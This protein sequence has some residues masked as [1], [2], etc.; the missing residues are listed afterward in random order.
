MSDIKRYGA[1]GGV[2]QGKQHMPFSR[3]VEAD[4]W[5]FMAVLKHARSRSGKKATLDTFVDCAAY[6][7]LEGECVMRNGG[8]S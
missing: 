5:L 1:E 8:V 6:A 2:G 4:G 7:S 3:A